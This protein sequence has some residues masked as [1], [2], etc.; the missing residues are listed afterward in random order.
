MPPE[1]IPRRAR[2]AAW[3][4]L[5]VAIALVPV[6]TSHVPVVSA[7]PREIDASRSWAFY[8]TLPAGEADAWTFEVAKGERLFLL[9][10]VPFGNDWRPDARLEGPLGE[11]PLERVDRIGYEAATPYAARDTWS[12]DVPAPASG[13]YVL[14]IAGEGGKY[15]LGFGLRE[16][17]SLYE[18]VTVPVLALRIHS[19]EGRPWWALAIPYA[20]SIAAAALIARPT[21]SA[22]N[23]LPRAA[24]ALFAGGATER[25]LA[26]A[27][28]LAQGAS[29]G[30]FGYLF[31]GATI[32]AGTGIAVLAWRARR[33]VALLALAIT[34][35]ASWTG[36]IVGPVLA[37]I[38]GVVATVRWARLPRPIK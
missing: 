19:W 30:A 6:A 7:G 36:A 3:L 4:L 14:T 38:A 34:G 17:F 24:A 37:G 5:V 9:I 10:S 25:L 27:I 28:A 21:L 1:A 8:E 29:P 18:W 2:S 16:G 32:A 12:L 15:A 33:P 26:L 11:I 31:T 20:L 13:P 22:Q 23:V 35:L